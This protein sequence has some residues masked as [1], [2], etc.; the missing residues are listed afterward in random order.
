MR[1]QSRYREMF[2]RQILDTPK[3]QTLHQIL[4]ILISDG[5]MSLLCS[6]SVQVYVLDHFSILLARLVNEVTWSQTPVSGSKTLFYPRKTLL[7]II[8][9]WQTS[10]MFT[11]IRTSSLSDMGQIVLPFPLL[12][13][14]GHMICFHKY[15]IGRSDIYHLCPMHQLY[16]PLHLDW[17]RL[18]LQI[19][20]TQSVCLNQFRKDRILKYNTHSWGN[21]GKK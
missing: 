15:S 4:K 16:R 9:L 14:N 18:I 2:E 11:S 3:I 19:M 21:R 17:G 7:L 12:G 6:R 1:R 8:K 10:L 13:R 20:E 5:T